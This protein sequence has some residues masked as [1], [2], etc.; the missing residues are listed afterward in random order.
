VELIS[1]VMAQLQPRLLTNV[2]DPTAPTLEGQQ[3]HLL[4]DPD[5]L[6]HGLDAWLAAL[7][8]ALVWVGNGF[9]YKGPEVCDTRGY[10]LRLPLLDEDVMSW[11]QSGSLFGPAQYVYRGGP[12]GHVELEPGEVAHAVINPRAGRRMGEGILQRYQDEL[13]L[14]YVTERAQYVVMKQGQPFGIISLNYDATPAEAGEYKQAFL[15]AV[16]NDGV[17]VIAGADFKPVQWSSSDLSLVET[18]S[19]NLRLAADIVGISPYL[20]GVPSES[21]VYSNMET[22]WANF[23]RVTLGRY[24]AALETMLSRCFPRGKKVVINTDVLLRADAATRWA[25]YEKAIDLGVS[26]PAE[27][28]QLERLPFDSRV[29]SVPKSNV[30]PAPAAP[31]TE[32]DA[33]DTDASGGEQ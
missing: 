15:K 11:E 1:G 24:I 3:P 23:I 4:Q 10:P 25:V 31:A 8:S 22:E 17:A 14:M 28:R 7:T 18:R 5:P 30:E 20:L 32:P 19:F 26:S 9:A 33:D 27:V 21:R 29:S 6:W 13:R 2:D 16:Q 12:T